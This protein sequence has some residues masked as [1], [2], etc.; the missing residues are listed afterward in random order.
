[1]KVT[2]LSKVDKNTAKR[3]LRQSRDL[4]LHSSRTFVVDVLKGVSKGDFFLRHFK[5][6]LPRGDQLLPRSYKIG[7]DAILLGIGTAIT[8]QGIRHSVILPENRERLALCISPEKSIFETSPLTS[9]GKTKVLT[10]IGE[11]KI[12][13]NSHGGF[14][15]IEHHC[16]RYDIVTAS[17]DK[18]SDALEPKIIELS[19]DS[20]VIG[21]MLDHSIKNNGVR[22]YGRLSGDWNAEI[23]TDAGNEQFKGP[24]ELVFKTGVGPDG[25]WGVHGV[26]VPT[27]S[28]NP[29]GSMLTGGR[30]LQAF[31]IA[32]QNFGFMVEVPPG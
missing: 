18:R 14:R 21:L 3:L 1:M 30:V 25:K 27:D 17:K 4:P 5:L 2:P 22:V 32:D 7:D 10:S 28:T 8:N 19:S 9:T 12:V 31:P 13:Y 24:G 26:L 23:K 6:E 29:F 16:F 15:S 20:D 11:T